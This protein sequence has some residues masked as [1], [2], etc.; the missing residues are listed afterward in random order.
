MLPVQGI[1]G[2]ASMSGSV[3]VQSAQSANSSL[4]FHASQKTSQEHHRTS[5]RAAGT[6]VTTK[7]SR[8][9]PFF[10][11]HEAQKCASKSA[12]LSPMAR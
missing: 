2:I 1:I 8:F 12:C 11:S 4:V 5:R 3:E 10:A 7:K 9:L 6:R